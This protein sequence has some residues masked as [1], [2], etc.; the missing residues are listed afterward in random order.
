MSTANSPPDRTLK[1]V[2][3]NSLDQSSTP[4]AGS[5]AS[6]PAASLQPNH[7]DQNTAANNSTPPKSHTKPSSTVLISPASELRNQILARD[8]K[9]ARLE[10]EILALRTENANLIDSQAAAEAEQEKL[11]KEM[12]SKDDQIEN[13]RADLLELQAI[14][15][16]IQFRDNRTDIAHKFALDQA[17]SRIKE[18]ETALENS[19]RRMEGLAKELRDKTQL[20]ILQTAQLNAIREVLN[21]TTSNITVTPARH[22]NNHGADND[23]ISNDHQSSHVSQL[24]AFPSL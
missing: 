5:A 7:N 23:G 12:A 14:H 16:S 22:I 18:M 8:S 1:S 6:D 17:N 20:L 9:L 11:A 3:H 4:N 19:N 24:P 2:A 21:S 10:Q 15:K 13:I